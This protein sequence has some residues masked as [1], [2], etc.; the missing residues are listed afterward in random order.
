MENREITVG[1]YW[2]I[3][4]K[5]SPIAAV[6]ITEELDQN[7]S[8]GIFVVTDKTLQTAVGFLTTSNFNQNN[9]ISKIQK[10][11]SNFNELQNSTEKSTK[12][13]KF[14]QNEN[15][16]TG[17]LEKSPSNCDSNNLSMDLNFNSYIDESYLSKSR[18]NKHEDLDQDD[19]LLNVKKMLR[20]ESM[21]DSFKKG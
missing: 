16:Y 7:E 2:V 8:E 5:S 10:K 18:K 17:P 3:Q 19:Y 15:Y 14:I 6:T 20:D 9:I 12:K 1:M 11:Q 4:R 21:E 13:P